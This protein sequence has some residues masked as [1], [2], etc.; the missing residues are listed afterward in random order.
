MRAQP[1]A[2]LDSGG[3]NS[4]SDVGGPPCSGCKQRRGWRLWSIVSQACSNRTVVRNDCRFRLW[5]APRTSIARGRCSG[6]ECVGIS[7]M[8]WNRHGAPATC[9]SGTMLMRRELWGTRR[10]RS[11]QHQQRNRLRPHRNVPMSGPSCGFSRRPARA[12]CRA[13]QS[14]LAVISALHACGLHLR[15]GSRFLSPAST[16]R[17]SVR[18]KAR[19]IWQVK[20]MGWPCGIVTAMHRLSAL[21]VLAAVCVNASWCVDGC[22]DPFAGSASYSTSS[23]CSTPS[24]NS[25]SSE[26]TIQCVVCVVPFE[27]LQTVT[28]VLRLET[29][30]Q[31]PNFEPDDPPATPTAGIDHPPRS[32]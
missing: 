26:S 18:T 32:L 24:S 3:R 23:S 27:Q 8:T 16:N 4:D 19:R 30:G 17:C 6:R 28:I 5:H 20:Q 10:T 21:I 29:T 2:C 15:W 22:I 11:A 31:I 25:D 1:A 9:P 14:H 13:R 12:I 7:G